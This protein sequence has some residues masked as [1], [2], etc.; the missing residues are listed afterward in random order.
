MTN[1]HRPCTGEVQS[2][3]VGSAVK[4]KEGRTRRI[5]KCGVDRDPE[6]AAGSSL[7]KTTHYN[8]F[9]GFGVIRDFQLNKEKYQKKKMP[10]C[11]MHNLLA[12]LAN[13]S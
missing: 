11:G 3:M 6:K 2:P 9:K 12:V 7:L 10:N 5:S 8:A 1:G 4:A 13:L